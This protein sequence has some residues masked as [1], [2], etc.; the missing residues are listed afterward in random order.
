MYKGVIIIFYSLFFI[1]CLETVRC[2]IEITFNNLK[3]PVSMDQKIHSPNGDIIGYSQLNHL[4][5]WEH[6]LLVKVYSDTMV[7]L[8]ISELL[9]KSIENKGGSA[10]INFKIKNVYKK[11]LRKS[12]ILWGTS[13]LFLGTLITIGGVN[14]NSNSGIIWGSV[15][16]L[17]GLGMLYNG[18]TNPKMTIGV[19]L[20][21]EIISF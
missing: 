1:S 17:L 20:Q 2:D 11:G 8:D 16:N 14:S 21:G 6:T 4:Q 5:R 3:Y 10:M 7:T 18:L 15:F 19:K 9:N 12:K 13:F